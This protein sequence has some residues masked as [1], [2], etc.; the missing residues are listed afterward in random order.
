VR[1][2][3]MSMSV[4]L[5]VCLSVHSEN[6][7]ITR[8][9]FTKFCT[10]CL[11]GP[12]LTALRY[13]TYFRFCGWRHIFT[14]RPFGASCVF[15]SG[16][17]TRQAL[18][19]EIPT[20]FC[21][22]VTTSKYSR[23]VAVFGLSLLCRIASLLCFVFQFWLSNNKRIAKQVRSKCSGSLPLSSFSPFCDSSVCK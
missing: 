21:S 4:C 20:E 23:W 16:D 10:C 22:T 18:T 8:P 11:Y 2:I 7:K 14:Q 15:L 3:V 13:V 9:N 17:R 5:S 19:A 1:S 12:P 6:S